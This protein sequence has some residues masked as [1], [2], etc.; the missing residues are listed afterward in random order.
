MAAVM[1]NLGWYRAPRADRTFIIIA[2]STMDFC[3][4]RADCLLFVRSRS[5][6][7]ILDTRGSRGGRCGEGMTGQFGP[8]SVELHLF[9]VSE[10]RH[11]AVRACA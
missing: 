1:Y 8:R 3:A 4:R 2:G 10:S 5:S 9:A 6:R 7:V 11:C